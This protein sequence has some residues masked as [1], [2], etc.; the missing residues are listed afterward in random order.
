[1][2]SLSDDIYTL[3]GDV[4]AV[5]SLQ[6]YVKQRWTESGDVGDSLD[7]LLCQ[8]SSDHAGGRRSPTMYRCVPF[9]ATARVRARRR[10]GDF[11]SVALR[12]ASTPLADKSEQADPV[13]NLFSLGPSAC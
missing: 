3:N 13:G 2:K 9:G 12:M 8:A 7:V 11:C 5:A 4:S 1:M 6:N 10:S